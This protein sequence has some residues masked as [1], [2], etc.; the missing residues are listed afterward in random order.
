M[1]EENLHEWILVVLVSFNY[2]YAA[3]IAVAIWS[4]LHLEMLRKRQLSLRSMFILT[5]MLA[6][7]CAIVRFATTTRD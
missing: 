6:A 4:V 5:A 1:P 3:F 7:S 2:L